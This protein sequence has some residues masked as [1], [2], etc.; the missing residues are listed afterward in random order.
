[1]RFLRRKAA[2]EQPP[3]EAPR[4]EDLIAYARAHVTSPG[5]QALLDEVERGRQ[6][7]E[8]LAAG[9]A[10]RLAELERIAAERRPPRAPGPLHA[11]EVTP[12]DA[13]LIRM[14]S[15]AHFGPDAVVTLPSG[16]AI[17]GA[18]MQRWIESSEEGQQR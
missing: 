1:M 13:A 17:T 8:R 9:A 14:M 11:H 16:K 12:A 10:E 15:S 2:R 18:E 6:R 3:P 5:A 7:R 4:E